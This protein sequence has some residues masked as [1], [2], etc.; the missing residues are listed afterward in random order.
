[1]GKPDGLCR[2]SREEKSEMDANFFDEGQLLYLENDYVEKEEDAEEVELEA[3]DVATWEKKNGLWV[4][5]QEHSLEVLHQHHDRQVAG[6]WG[7]HRNQVLVSRNFISD[8]WSEDVARYVV[9]RVKCQKSKVDR[10]SR[11]TKLV[12]MPT[13]ERLFEEIA[14]D[15]IRE[16]PES[17]GF[18]AILVV[19]DRFIKVQHY[20]PAKTTWTAADVANSYINDIWKLYGPLRYRTSDRSPQ[21]T[22][23]FL[24]EL[25]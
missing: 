20:I 21:F 6:H 1:M 17:E 2:H 13:G 10:H 12:P 4:V 5:P 16:L 19:T 9:G 7:R 22:L 8:K 11:Q 14:M 3:I 15:F 24:K 23:K 25:N 18:N